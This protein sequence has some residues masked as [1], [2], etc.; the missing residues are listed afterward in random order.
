MGGSFFLHRS[1]GHLPPG[2]RSIIVFG[3]MYYTLLSITALIG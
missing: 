2:L 3:A 1:G